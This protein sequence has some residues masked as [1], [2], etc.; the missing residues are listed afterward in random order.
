MTPGEIF[1]I[2]AFVG[3]AIGFL[4]AWMVWRRGL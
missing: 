4:T 2:G 3:Y 1:V